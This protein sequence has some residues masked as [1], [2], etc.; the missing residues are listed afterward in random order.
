MTISTYASTPTMGP[1]RRAGSL[2][3][4]LRDV[5][6]PLV[7][8]LG[9]LAL[10]SGIWNDA[11]A[12]DGIGGLRGIST[13]QTGPA[14]SSQ[15]IAGSVEVFLGQGVWRPGACTGQ[16]NFQAFVF[17]PARSVEVGAGHRGD[18]ETLE[19]L[20]AQ[21]RPGFVDVSTR[22][23]APVGCNQTV[24]T[25]KVI[26]Q[27]RIQEWRFEGRLPNREPYVLVADGRASDGSEGRVFRR[28]P[29]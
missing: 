13:A 7:A 23:C 17:T 18:G 10:A 14:A 5:A 12:G 25:Y 1:S 28:C 21:L 8:A 9:V 16:G 20:S 27:D 26:D 29:Q 19:M 2:R 24:E 4:R 15:A 22:V 6:G 3:A 11:R